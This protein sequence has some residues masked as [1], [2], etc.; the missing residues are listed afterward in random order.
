MPLSFTGVAA[1][2][3]CRLPEGVVAWRFGVPPA[4]DLGGRPRLLAGVS[5][6]AGCA[7]T[8]PFCP[9]ASAPFAAL[10]DSRR[11]RRF[12][13]SASSGTSYGSTGDSRFPEARDTNVSVVAFL[14]AIAATWFRGFRVAGSNHVLSGGDGSVAQP[15][16]TLIAQLRRV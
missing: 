10:V 9:S 2:W 13:V 12:G 8:F 7:S 4:A 16:L 5:S 6:T 3:R 14:R 15:A 1:S 11:R